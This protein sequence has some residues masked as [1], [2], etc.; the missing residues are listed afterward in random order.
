MVHDQTSTKKLRRVLLAVA[1][2]MLVVTGGLI[3]LSMPYWGA[4]DDPALQIA[5]EPETEAPEIPTE[6]PTEPTLPPP[7]PNPYGDLD[8]EDAVSV[9]AQVVRLGAKYGADLI[10][11]ETMND[12]YETKAALL[13]AKENSS[14]P[15]FVSNAYGEDGK[16]MTG[17]SPE[18]MCALLEG[19]ENTHF[20]NPDGYHHEDHYTCL[21]D[22]LTIGRLSIETELIRQ[23]AATPEY[24][25]TV[26]PGRTLTWKN[27][28]FLLQESFP[29]Y[30]CPDAI[31]L[32]TGYTR[33]A[34]GC[35][36]AAFEKDGEVILIGIF[37]SEDKASRFPDVLALYAALQ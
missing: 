10:F 5:S 15:V 6:D 14:L 32:K 7:P 22:L 37:G 31:G 13:A 20:V 36:L 33:A 1:A 26:A 17:A 4:E 12:S 28:N 29:D 11:I 3:L 8:F 35:L 24:T 2:V 21:Q 34:G 27:T 19:M 16:L 18:A 30:Y 23:I 9:F 25:A